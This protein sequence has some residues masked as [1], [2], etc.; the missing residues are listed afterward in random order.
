[1]TWNTY[2]LVMVIF[3]RNSSAGLFFRLWNQFELGFFWY[4]PTPRP[5]KYPMVRRLIT[6]KMT[7]AN[8]RPD[9]SW[10]FTKW[11]LCHDFRRN[12][13]Q[14]CFSWKSGAKLNFPS[15]WNHCTASYK[16]KMAENEATHAVTKKYRHNFSFEDFEGVWSSKRGKLVRVCIHTWMK[17]LKSKDFCFQKYN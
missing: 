9:Y 10:F 2:F 7:S 14:F 4:L 12:H 6:L 15:A 11:R 13:R 17:F 16:V 5:L 1:M 3:H 8:H